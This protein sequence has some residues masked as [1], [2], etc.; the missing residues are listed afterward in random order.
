MR[1]LMIPAI[2]CMMMASPLALA[3]QAQ[4]SSPST[5]PGLSTPPDTS[6]TPGSSVTPDTSST[7]DTSAS[8]S[9]SSLPSASD[10]TA[11]SGSGSASESG[12]RSYDEVQSSLEQAGIENV[13]VLNAAYLVR[14]TS[15]DGEQVSFVIEP[16]VGGASADSGATASTGTSPGASASAS[17]SGMSGSQEKV[18]QALTDAGFQNIEIVEAAYL[19]QGETKDGDQITMM[20]DASS[21]G[22]SA[23][24]G[25]SGS[26]EPSA[27]G[28]SSTGSGTSGSTTG[29]G[30]AD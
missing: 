5:T 22:Q 30:T 8:G 3:Q 20:I 6:A 4:D 26:S 18:R 23:S 10:Q 12:V 14:A 9:S 27:A 19:A 25:A 17:A 13:E 24:G 1:K 11:A 29:G 7:P 28:S 21:G 15:K 16:P 2:A